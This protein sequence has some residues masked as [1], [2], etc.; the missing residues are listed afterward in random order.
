MQ[1]SKISTIVLTS[2]G[3]TCTV[4]YYVASGMTV[5]GGTGYSY[6]RVEGNMDV[7]LQGLGPLYVCMVER[8]IVSSWLACEFLIYH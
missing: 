3:N 1:K 7:V 8:C 4:T 6:A 2:R 5:G